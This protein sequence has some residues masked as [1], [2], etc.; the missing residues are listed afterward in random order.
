MW[1]KTGSDDPSNDLEDRELLSAFMGGDQS[2]FNRLVRKYQDMI[3]STCVRM[4]GNY[5]DG[6]DA[7]QEV[8]VQVYKHANK[9]RGDSEFT[10]WL[11]RITMNICR[12][13]HRSWWKRLF[14]SAVHVDRESTSKEGIVPVELVAETPSPADDL[15][16]KRRTLKVRNAIRNL[17][18][19]QR[20][21]IVLCDV[22]E[23]SYDEICLILGVALGTVKSRIARAREA[24][25]KELQGSPHE[26]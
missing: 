26:S 2:G 23:N 9:F 21:I 24:L 17:P 5:Q 7:A 8:F 16:I 22:K 6:E 15:D 25:K 4:A 13:Q 18:E 19:S 14:K 11:Y 20:E 10:T 12:N 3:V 1:N